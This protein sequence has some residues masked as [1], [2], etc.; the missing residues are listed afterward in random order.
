MFCFSRLFST[1]KRF[2]FAV[3][4]R[5][6]YRCF[7]ACCF[8]SLRL[9]TQVVLL[10]K[11]E[12][13]PVLAEAKGLTLFYEMNPSGAQTVPQDDFVAALCEEARLAK[14][15]DKTIGTAVDAGDQASIKKLLK[16]GVEVDTRDEHGWTGLMR[17][18][19]NSD[20]QMAALLLKAGADPNGEV[21][22]HP[23]SH[24]GSTPLHFACGRGHLELVKMLLRYKAS[25]DKKDRRGLTPPQL[26]ERCGHA[27]VV[28]LI[29]E[30]RKEH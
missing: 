27:P 19:L 26:A 18:C 6:S 9:L 5:S 15:A 8:A 30:W 23:M 28:N 21:E 10:K 4:L 14:M 17:A 12:T 11:I 20:Y 3:S 22:T 13:D 24:D 7:A 1:D 16:Q 2:F 29:I 25:L